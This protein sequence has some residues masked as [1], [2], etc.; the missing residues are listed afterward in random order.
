[1]S[2]SISQIINELS[3]INAMVESSIAAL[4][5]QRA[6]VSKAIQYVQNTFANSESGKQISAAIFGIAGHINSA[7]GML[8]QLRHDIDIHV[9]NLQK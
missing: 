5:G 6:E 4:S 3:K 1:M 9:K 7:E 2:A 8:N